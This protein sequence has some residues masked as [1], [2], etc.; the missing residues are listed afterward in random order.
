MSWVS[1]PE[2]TLPTLFNLYSIKMLKVKYECLRSIDTDLFVSFSVALDIYKQTI[3][4]QYLFPQAFE[5]IA[6]SSGGI[7]TSITDI[8]MQILHVFHQAA[9]ITLKIV[10]L[11]TFV[12]KSR[13]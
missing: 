5:A 9:L 6:S 8:Y 3:F 2:P 4:L 13:N 1:T 7:Q 12:L 11:V 10:T